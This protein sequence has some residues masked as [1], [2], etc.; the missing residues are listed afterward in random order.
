VVVEALCLETPYFIVQLNLFP[1][2][3]L[4]AMQE[5]GGLR[6]ELWEGAKMKG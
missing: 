5:D 3:T 4:Q 6:E 2:E 1:L